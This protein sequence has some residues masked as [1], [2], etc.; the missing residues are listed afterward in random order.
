MAVNE[1][2]IKFQCHQAQSSVETHQQT[3]SEAQQRLQEVDTYSARINEEMEK[4]DEF[5]GENKA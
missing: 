3:Y 2:I 5:G 4:L 1:L